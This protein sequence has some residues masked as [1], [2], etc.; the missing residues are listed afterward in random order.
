MHVM[1]SPSNYSVNASSMQGDA[2]LSGEAIL[3]LKAE[4]ESDLKLLEELPAR[5]KLKKRRYEA[6]LLFAPPG[7]DPDAPIKGE[8]FIQSALDV[9]VASKIES[10]VLQEHKAAGAPLN[11]F[12][13]VQEP[14]EDDEAL[15]GRITWAGELKGLLDSSPVGVS[16][17]DALAKLKQTSLGERVSKGEKGFYNA[18]AR[19]EKSGSLVKSGGLLYSKQLVEAMESRGEALPDVST[20]TRRRAGGS[21]AV[22]LEVLR[23]NPDGLNAND[24]RAKLAELPGVSQSITNHH[25]YIYNVLGTLMGQGEIKKDAQGVYKIKGVE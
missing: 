4:Y 21:A 17:K 11:L 8:P 2:M 19:L 14:E 12:G 10:E 25:H 16:H 6:S 3:R 22:V 24:L 23:A 13:E 1:T 9:A 20:E 18:V 7:F 5:I 15:T